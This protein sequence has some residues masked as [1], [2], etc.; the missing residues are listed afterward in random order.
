MSTL[1]EKLDQEI[2]VGG[3]ARQMLKKH[4]TSKKTKQPYYTVL[5][6]DAVGPYRVEVVSMDK[7]WIWKRIEEVKKDFLMELESVEDI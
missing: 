3:K 2:S 6:T 1:E 4:M 5:E 7:R